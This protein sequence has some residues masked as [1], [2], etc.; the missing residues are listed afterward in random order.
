MPRFWILMHHLTDENCLSN[1][2]ASSFST[3]LITVQ[4]LLLLLFFAHGCIWSD[5]AMSLLAAITETE[6][7]ERFSRV[8]GLYTQP[9]FNVRR[10]AW[11]STDSPATYIRWNMHGL[12]TSDVTSD[13]KWPC[14]ATCLQL[15]GGLTSGL[16]FPLNPTV[17]PID[18]VC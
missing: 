4:S 14:V 7:D 15:V 16:L 9:E 17:A 5:R 3:Q 12:P 2:E 11:A 18:L 8:M 1:E 13:M 10:A 6:I